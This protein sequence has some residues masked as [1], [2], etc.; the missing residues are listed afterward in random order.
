MKKALFG[1]LA[2]AVIA[3]LGGAFVTQGADVTFPI[4]ITQI[5]IEGN[6]RVATGDVL[7]A[8]PFKV[9]GILNEQADLKPASQAI[10]DLGWFS[11]VLPEVTQDGRV[12]FRVTENP[13]IE[14]FE[15]TGNTNLRDI[16]VFGV[17]LFSVRIMQTSKLKQVLRE[18]DIRIGRTFRSGDLRDALDGMVVAYNDRGYVLA[19]VGDVK[20]APTLSI[21]VI[22]GH[23]AGNR[24]SGLTTVPTEVAAAMIDLPTDR[25]LLKQELGAVM[26]RL[27]ESVFFSDVAVTPEAGPTRNSVY[28]NWGLTERTVLAAPTPLGAVE[29]EG[30]TQFPTGVVESQVGALPAGIV[31]NYAVLKAI[32][33]VYSLYTH[34]GFVMTRFSGARVDG[35]VLHLRV[36]E[37]IV[38]EI[39]LAEETQTHR[40]VLEKSLEIHVGRILTRRDLQVSQQRLSALGYFD[41]IVVDPQWAGDG[42]RVT[43]SLSDKTTL[44]GLNGSLAFEPATG[45]IVGELSVKQ[46]NIFGSGQDVSLTYKRGVSPEG[47]PEASTWELGYTTLATRT[48]FDRIAVNLYRKTQET[49]AEEN[50][51]DET[52]PT[53]YLTLGG[54]I[55]FSYP[56]ADY[57]D[58]VIG[59][60]HELER[61]LAE[62]AWTPVDS[63]TMS[64]QEDS[65]D[66]MAFPTRGTRR[67]VSLEK[68]GGFA[69][70]KEYTK[71]DLAWIRFVPFYDDLFAGMDHV[72]ALRLKVGLGD[73]GLSGAQAYELGGPTTIRGVDAATVQR[74]AVANVEYRLKLTEGFVLTAFLDAGLDLDSIRL[75]DTKASTGLELGITAAGVFVRL[76][77]VWALGED[78]SW[79]P[80]FDFGFGPMF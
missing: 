20:V 8:V 16:S 69:V 9:G 62:T 15:I 24:V 5:S 2:L 41:N 13:V 34:A 10:F 31:D 56:V 4:Q 18:H 35:D 3:L 38:S 66:D 80:R 68:A 72:L 48:E 57:A 36:D 71:V 17:K 39:V 79:T 19:M 65:T 77:I 78:A 67:S 64:L 1:A 50:D 43:V 11:E 22:E 23:V 59:Y 29:L 70:G 61:T 28:L 27:R 12:A 47:K 44:G 49:G 58:L 60:R 76:D 26:T 74:M 52:D 73:Q 75:D 6:D 37:G 46:R 32:E 25:P 63:V 14:K 30:V 7:K 54:N 21:E 45:G 53:T 51:G 40:R 55:Q 33:G 42:V